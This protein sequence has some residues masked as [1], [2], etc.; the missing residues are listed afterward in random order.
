MSVISQMRQE[1]ERA[2]VRLRLIE[3]QM[4]NTNMVRW[5]APSD[6]QRKE[7]F[8]DFPGYK[9]QA[10]EY[11]TA[12]QQYVFGVFPEFWNIRT[13]NATQAKFA[14]D[15]LESNRLNFIAYVA[16]MYKAQE[17]CPDI[18]GYADYPNVIGLKYSDEISSQDY[19]LVGIEESTTYK[20]LKALKD[21]KVTK[22][23]LLIASKRYKEQVEYIKTIVERY[24][25]G[26]VPGISKVFNNK[27]V[28]GYEE[29]KQII[30]K[31]I[32]ALI[33]QIKNGLV[34]RT[35]GFEIEVPD[36]KGVEPLPGI[37]KGDDGSLRSE[38]N[39]D[40]E[41]DCNDCVYH[42]CNC[43]NCEYGNS[44]PEH[45]GDSY[46]ATD[47][48]SAEFRTVGGIQRVKHTGML[49]LCKDLNDKD[50]EMNDSAGTHI[51]VYAQDL[52]TH[53]VGQVLATYS[54][55]ENII[56]A[57]AGRQNVN[58]AKSIPNAHVAKALRKRNPV[59]VPVKAQAVNVTWLTQGERGT[60]EFRQM[61][62][63][64]DGD[65]ITLW[66]WFCRGFVETAKRGA[67]FSEFKDAKTLQDI[68]NVF[69]KYD[70]TPES[71]NPGIV[72]PGSKTDKP[73]VTTVIH[74]VAA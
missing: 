45:C 6:I 74:K 50:A 61:D 4:K 66:A 13:K 38:N 37:E 41:C 33:E 67:K 73:L 70:F 5:M 16:Y 32:G 14:L 11:T 46:C 27:P 60:I 62:C 23:N 64:L 1:A 34:S 26:E 44:D 51:H 30:Q 24:S 58:Y 2:I 48:D 56:T 57:I 18:G 29:K 43:E 20:M 55:L 47:V 21:A 52:T 8:K 28:L 19:N 53:Q 69:A 65:K 22:D 63:N 7:I 49:K 54:W 10:S 68:V 39:E 71:E 25:L 12:I 17:L 42:E 40:C 15:W 9:E 59:L 36:A 31:E 72:I 35:W 3:D